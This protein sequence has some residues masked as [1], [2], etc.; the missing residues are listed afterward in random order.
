IYQEDLRKVGIT[1]NLRLVTFETMIKL[2]DDRN[3]DMVSAAY[4]GVLFPSPEQELASSLADVK[5]T[6][7]ITGF[8]NKRADEII[9]AYKT[10][11]DFNKRAALLRELDGIVM[12][13]HHWIL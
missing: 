12:A 9:A 5:N 7:N 8:K 13:E 11:F 4:T 1:L 3:F 2:T 6:N 10:E